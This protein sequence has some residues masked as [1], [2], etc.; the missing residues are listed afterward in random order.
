MP[1]TKALMDWRPLFWIGLVVSLAFLLAPA[2]SLLDTKIWVS[3]WLPFADRIDAMNA[4][5]HSDKWLHLGIF[6]LLGWLGAQ[7]WRQQPARRRQLLGGL[8]L[9]AV[10]T[11]CLQYWVPGRSP[12]LGDLLA[13]LAGLLLGTLAARAGARRSQAYAHHGV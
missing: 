7:A 12:S 11:E 3:R 9:V 8:L 13:D 1:Q 4:T 5:Q 10:A 2:E 6:A